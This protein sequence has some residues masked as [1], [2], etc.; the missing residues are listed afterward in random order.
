MKARLILWF[1]GWLLGFVD[2]Y[3]VH[4]DPKRKRKEEDVG[5]R[6]ETTD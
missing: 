1:I 5:K 2:G 3:H 6:I 4:K